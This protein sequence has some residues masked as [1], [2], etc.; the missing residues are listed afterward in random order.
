[1]PKEFTFFLQTLETHENLLHAETQAIA[2]KRLDTIDSILNRKEDS[3]KLLLQAKDNIGFDPRS[4]EKA[5]ELIDRVLELQKRNADLFR[6]LVDNENE[7]KN[8][9]ESPNLNPINKRLKKAYENNTFSQNTRLD[10]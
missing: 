10:F 6:R 4:N 3:L 1:V 2:A 7:K 8:T 5:N 9:S